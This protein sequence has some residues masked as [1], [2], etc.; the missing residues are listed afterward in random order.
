MLALWTPASAAATVMPLWALLVCLLPARAQIGSDCSD[1]VPCAGNQDCSLGYCRCPQG[2]VKLAKDCIPERGFN[3]TCSFDDQCVDFRLKCSEA[4][5]CACVKYFHWDQ[6]SQQCLTFKDLRYM[7]SDLKQKYNLD[8][9]IMSETKQVFSGMLWS[10]LAVLVIGLVLSS[11]CL[12]YGC[13]LGRLCCYPHNKLSQERVPRGLSN[14]P[15]HGQQETAFPGSTDSAGRLQS[16]TSQGTGID[17]IPALYES[18]S[19][20]IV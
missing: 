5:R 8:G 3:E 17:Y 11:G 15:P 9:Q 4:G 10:G 19:F 7:L 2:F 13:C 1:V 18:T 6:F 12:F 16:G 20:D 14:H